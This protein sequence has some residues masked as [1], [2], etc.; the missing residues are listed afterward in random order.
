M[1]PTKNTIRRPS[2]FLGTSCNLLM[3]G[4]GNKYSTKS[5]A[6]SKTP[7]TI[8]RAAGSAHFAN[9]VAFHGEPFLGDCSLQDVRDGATNVLMASEVHLE[10]RRCHDTERYVP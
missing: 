10:E 4:N 1:N 3:M 6:T 9:V 7:T 5:V 8:S 2:S